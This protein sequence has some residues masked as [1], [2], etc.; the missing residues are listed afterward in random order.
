VPSE[1]SQ[2][3][4]QLKAFERPPIEKW[5]PNKTVDFD[6]RILKNG[7]WVHEGGVISRRKLVKLFSTVLA[8]R[9]TDYYLV[10]PQVRY[11]IQ[12]EDAPF[13]GV[14]LTT[15]NTDPDHHPSNQEIFIRTNMDEVVRVDAAHPL[16]VILE[17][18]TQEPSPYL[19]VRDGLVARLTRPVF[20]ELAEMSEYCANEPCDAG[21]YS[22]GSF[23]PLA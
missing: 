16:N 14:E 5:H 1:L 22:A 19:E 4:D 8:L 21:V 6:L 2:L 20:Y 10:T 11:L 18:R 3:F 23:F 15:R 9:D 13:L 12:V 7:D 17:P